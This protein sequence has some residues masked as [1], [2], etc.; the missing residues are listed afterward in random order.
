MTKATHIKIRGCFSWENVF[1]PPQNP[2]LWTEKNRK[3]RALLCLT[4]GLRPLRI[5]A[6]CTSTRFLRELLSCNK[7][8]R[9]ACGNAF[10]QSQKPWLWT[11]KK[12][13]KA[14]ALLCLAWGRLPDAANS[15]DVTTQF[16]TELKKEKVLKDKF[17]FVT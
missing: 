7:D 15:S 10:G 5:Q 13:Q 8:G 17:R 11:E 2:L 14:L 16:A 12:K 6:I 9:F 1:R 4:S 3:A